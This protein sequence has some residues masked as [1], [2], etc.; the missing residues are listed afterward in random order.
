[1]SNNTI[2]L[3]SL[4]VSGFAALTAVVLPLWFRYRDTKIRLQDERDSLLQRILTVKSLNFSIRVQY[5]FL[6]S[7]H[8]Q[9]MTPEQRSHTEKMIRDFSKQEGWTM[10]L[11]EAVRNHGAKLTREQIEE[12]KDNMR[13]AE[14]DASDSLKYI[15]TILKKFD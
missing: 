1:M 3:L 13:V 6:M 8:G 9:N 15:E 11:S 4:F 5:G 7:Q 12:I 2:S 10:T 14:S